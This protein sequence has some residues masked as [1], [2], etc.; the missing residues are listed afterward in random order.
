MPVAA[1]L[2]SSGGGLMEGLITD[3]GAAGLPSRTHE[4]QTTS[5]D[6]SVHQACGHLPALFMPLE[7]RRDLPIQEKNE[8]STCLHSHIYVNNTHIN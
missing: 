1:R 6:D 4:S 2:T 3:S 7:E 5:I 8:A